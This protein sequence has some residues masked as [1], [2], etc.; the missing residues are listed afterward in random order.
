VADPIN[1][2]PADWVAK[3]EAYRRALST[4]QQS[5]SELSVL[6]AALNLGASSLGLNRWE[7]AIK[8]YQLILDEPERLLDPSAPARTMANV[9]LA[10]AFY[11]RGDLDVARAHAKAAAPAVLVLATQLDVTQLALRLG[12]MLAK[13]GDVYDAEALLQYASNFD[14][15][16]PT[17]KGS[18]QTPADLT[19]L[20]ARAAVGLARV[21]YNQQKGTSAATLLETGIHLMKTLGSTTFQDAAQERQLAAELYLASRHFSEAENSIKEALSFWEHV[22]E[23]LRTDDISC[24]DILG[25]VYQGQGDQNRAKETYSTALKLRRQR[26][27]ENHWQ[28]AWL[29]YEVGG[30]LVN[31]SD[32]QAA[33]PLL[34]S[35]LKWFKTRLGTQDV[36]TARSANLLGRLYYNTKRTAKAEPL[37]A[38]TTEVLRTHPE[39]TDLATAALQ[40]G[41]LRHAQHHEDQALDDLNLAWTTYGAVKA[42]DTWAVHSAALLGWAKYD[43]GDTVGAQPLLQTAFEH[44]WNGI[45]SDRALVA[46]L[47]SQIKHGPE[48]DESP[49][50]AELALVCDQPLDATVGFACRGSTGTAP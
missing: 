17:V 48:V 13:D 32:Y 3:H 5:S 10:E 47:L 44:R 50:R 24:W 33:E 26:S 35:S 11:Q 19:A 12:S 45:V 23:P 15:S 20:H 28:T 46:Y 37:L 43:A 40:L 18:T 8:V 39:D 31:Q 2:V 27:G 36:Y 29:K 41:E 49:Y 7:E 22:P 38:I 9:G 1:E 21:R 16:K 6:L 42:P 34:Q 25:A 14:A 4:A 30:T